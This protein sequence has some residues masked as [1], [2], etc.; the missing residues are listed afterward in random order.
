MI[1]I[2]NKRPIKDPCVTP[3]EMDWGSDVNPFNTT[4]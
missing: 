3:N 2:N 4:L 1:D